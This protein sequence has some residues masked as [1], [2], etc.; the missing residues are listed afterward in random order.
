MK[1]LAYLTGLTLM[2]AAAGCE[3]DEHHHHHDDYRGGAY[4]GNYNGYGYQ[5][6]PAPAPAPVYRDYDH[7]DYRY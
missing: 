6:Y 7:R 5:T 4:D 3:W 2:F 1:L